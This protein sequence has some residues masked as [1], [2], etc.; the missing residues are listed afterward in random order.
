VSAVDS[1]VASV[2]VMRR[3]PVQAQRVDSL[4]TVDSGLIGRFP[5]DWRQIVA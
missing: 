4:F 3:D 1:G 2:V 5:Q